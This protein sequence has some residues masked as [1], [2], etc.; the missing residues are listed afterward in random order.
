MSTEIYYFSGTGNSLV[1][2]RDI[3]RKTGGR[4]IPIATVTD[5]QKVTLARGQHLA[6]YVHAVIPMCCRLWLDY[7][8]ALT[9]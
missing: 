4:L 7:D 2:A 8:L 6:G 9:V 5:Y 1:V 3:A